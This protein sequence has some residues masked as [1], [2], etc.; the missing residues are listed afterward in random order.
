MTTAT[1]T[2]IDK[3]TWPRGPWDNEPDLVLGNYAGLQTLI[4][5]GP[6]GHLCGYVGVPEGHYLY[7]ID[8]DELYAVTDVHGGLTYASTWEDYPGIWWFGFDCA[9]AGDYCPAPC[10]FKYGTYRPIEYVSTEVARLAD[11]LVAI[12]APSPMSVSDAA[13]ALLTALENSAYTELAQRQL[14]HALQQESSQ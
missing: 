7:G 13:K 11:Q 6:G 9:H 1:N 10:F 8:Y 4:K 3:S 5:R 14:R 2:S 12:A